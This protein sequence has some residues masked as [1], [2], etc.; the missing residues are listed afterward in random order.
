[1][2]QTNIL[3]KDIFQT[4]RKK[5]GKDADIYVYLKVTAPHVEFPKYARMLWRH[6]MLAEMW[7]TIA[8]K[9]SGGKV[10]YLRSWGEK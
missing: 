9:L 10:N 1:M 4:Y 3:A 2:D 5:V 6:G 8:T 7:G